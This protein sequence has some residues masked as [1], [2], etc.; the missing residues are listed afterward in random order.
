MP[1]GRGA[2]RWGRKSRSGIE[3]SEGGFR[4]EPPSGSDSTNEL[5][6]VKIRRASY[7]LVKLAAAYFDICGLDYLDRIIQKCVK[8]DLGGLLSELQERIEGKGK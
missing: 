5:T 2:D 4:L 7:R 3:G 1:E 6:P 8:E